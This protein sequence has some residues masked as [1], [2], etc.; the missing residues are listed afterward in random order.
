MLGKDYWSGGEHSRALESLA[1]GQVERWQAGPA[2]SWTVYQHARA[3]RPPTDVHET[4]DAFTV[5]VE[6]AGMQG[7]EFGVSLTGNLLV[8]TGVR[9]SPVPRGICH[10]MESYY[11]EFRTEIVI[12]A[13]I[14]ADGITAHYA[15]GFLTV[16]IPKARAH[17]IP[18]RAVDRQ[19]GESSHNPRTGGQH[20]AGASKSNP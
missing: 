5:V 7:G 9:P 19:P 16:T 3:W 15:D 18:V 17:R 11:G 14:D 10:Q 8:I 6:V 4:D 1:S 13:A 20:G 12:V 2:G